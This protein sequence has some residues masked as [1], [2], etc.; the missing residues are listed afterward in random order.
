MARVRDGEAAGEGY[1]PSVPRKPRMDCSW[2]A[3][4]QGRGP[5]GDRQLASATERKGRGGRAYVGGLGGCSGRWAVVD[6]DVRCEG[7]AA[8]S[9]TVGRG[10]D[11]REQEATD[12]SARPSRPRSGQRAAGPLA[13]PRPAP[14][15]A[16][17]GRATAGGGGGGAAG[18]PTSTSGRRVR[19]GRWSGLRGASGLLLERDMVREGVSR[20]DRQAWRGET[21]ET[22]DAPCPSSARCALTLRAC[23]TV[24]G[25]TMPSSLHKR[26]MYAAWRSYCRR[27]SGKERPGSARRRASG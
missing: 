21:P 13:R 18:R 12:H 2:L 22:A 27:A 7:E 1:W 8:A 16:C 17:C 5:A 25:S 9:A 3:C 6:L 23:G 24:N 26:E 15:S 14:R 20:G 10:R 19:G 4:A 11:E